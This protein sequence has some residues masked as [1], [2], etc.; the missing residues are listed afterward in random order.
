MTRF[1]LFPMS[2]ARVTL[3]ALSLLGA[4]VVATPLTACTQSAGPGQG[5]GSAAAKTSKAGQAGKASGKTSRKAVQR[6][7]QKAVAKMRASRGTSRAPAK[8]APLKPLPPLPK[9]V[10]GPI[11]AHELTKLSP[12]L[13]AKQLVH[14]LQ[15]A[16]YDAEHLGLRQ[17]SFKLSYLDKKRRIKIEAKGRWTSRS[18]AEVEISSLSRDGKPVAKDTEPH[19]KMYQALTFRLRRLLD[20]LGKGF[21]TRRLYA[22]RDRPGKLAA[23]KGGKLSLTMDVK[24][25]FNAEKVVVLVDDKSRIE[26]VTRRSNRGVVRAMSY[27]Y[28]MIDG[29]NLVST[30][31]ASV[32]FEGKAQI[33]RR[34]R[35]RLMSMDGMNFQFTYAKFGRFYLPKSIYRRSPKIGQE[36]AIELS[37]RK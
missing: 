9:P 22:W 31:T 12:K 37:Y 4:A 15:A 18:P 11:P 7:V 25:E 32:R 35:T 5:K 29:R 14:A 36:I 19:K 16:H 23:V 33:K 17:L 3:G 26:K 2:G 27:R 20:G 21:L 1:S 8:A 34:M 28:R 24:N 13:D 30:A 10:T 6:A